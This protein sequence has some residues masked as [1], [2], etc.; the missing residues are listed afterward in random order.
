VTALVAETVAPSSDATLTPDDSWLVPTAILE[1][2]PE[3]TRERH[4]DT[5]SQFAD[6]LRPIA[7]PF[8]AALTAIRRS[9]PGAKPEPKGKPSASLSH[10]L[11][12]RQTPV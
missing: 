10:P 8:N 5:V 1:L 9:I 7:V 3:E 6:D 2:Y 12:S 4:R 11:P